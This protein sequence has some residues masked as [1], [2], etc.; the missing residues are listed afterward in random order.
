MTTRRA[1]I[2]LIN[3]DDNILLVKATTVKTF[4]LQ[5]YTYTLK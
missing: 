5:T 3:N 1:G 4:K 2:I